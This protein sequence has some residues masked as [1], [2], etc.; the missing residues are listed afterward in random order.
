MAI[1]GFSGFLKSLRLRGNT[2]ATLIGNVSDS[3]KTN[4]TNAILPMSD[5]TATGA[6]TTNGATVSVSAQG[7]STLGL[8]IT[9]TWTGTIQIEGSIDGTNYESVRSFRLSDGVLVSSTTSNLASLIAASGF[10]L[11]RARASAWASGTATIAFDGGAGAGI[12]RAIQFY[13]DS[14]QATAYIKGGTN[15]TKIGNHLDRLKSE[16]AFNS[17]LRIETSTTPVAINSTT[18]YSTL[19][20]HTGS[21]LFYAL[22]LIGG[23]TALVPRLQIDG[24]TVFDNLDL[25]GS[26]WSQFAATD[27][28]TDKRMQ[29]QGIVTQAANFFFS[30]RIPI[31]F[32]TSI[33]VS[34][35]KSGGSDFNTGGYLIYIQKD[36]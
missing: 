27:Q 4:V 9:G 19:Y 12:V 25:S 1:A 26:G 6:I 16:Q 36:T 28:T 34:G 29:G 22:Q 8:K 15:D 33:T 24:E 30:L 32:A 2:D 10:N 7:L 20:T 5:R 23:N 35:K 18:V 14:L 31:R 3:L 21:G 17:K 11:I 13:N